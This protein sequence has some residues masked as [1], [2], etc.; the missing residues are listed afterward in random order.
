MQAI[1]RDLLC[2]SMKQLRE[3]E[4]CAHVYD[5]VIVECGMEVTVEEVCELM[6]QVPDWATGLELRAD[7]YEGR[8]YRKD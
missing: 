3:Y 5:E 6:G 1:S 7:G 8:F 2:Y 4:V